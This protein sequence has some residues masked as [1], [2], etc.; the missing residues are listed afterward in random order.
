V[1]AA[2]DPAACEALFARNGWEGAWRDGIFSFHHF[3]STA[4]EVRGSCAATPA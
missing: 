4:H 2:R 3:H 1:D